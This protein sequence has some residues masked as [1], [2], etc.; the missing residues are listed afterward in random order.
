MSVW[1]AT[2]PAMTTGIDLK[3]ERIRA[4]VPQAAVA[5]RMGVARATI[6]RWESL[7]VVTEYKARYY[8][9]ALSDITDVQPV[10]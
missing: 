2:V 1:L 5:Q 3:I 8:R 6:S 4:R 9:D 7:P 10:R